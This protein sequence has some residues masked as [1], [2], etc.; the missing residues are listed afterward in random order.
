EGRHISYAEVRARAEALARGLVGA[1]VVKGARVGILLPNRPEW[2]EAFYA[3][4]LI[5]AVVVPINTFASSGER[6]H[7]LRHGDVSVLLLQQRLL[8][9]SYL[10]ELLADHP[11]LTT[12]RAGAIRCTALPQLRRV[13][14]LGLDEPLG[15][16]ET[17]PDLLACGAE[18]SPELV[19]AL[20]D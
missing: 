18:V 17:W 14:C 8:K 16:I 3:A 13:C 7:I 11:E 6:D 2:I 1:G 9:R 12:G 4:A 20:S 5:G 19:S 10:D 15:A